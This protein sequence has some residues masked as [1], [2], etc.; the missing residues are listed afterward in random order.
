[1]QQNNHLNLLGQCVMNSHWLINSRNFVLNGENIFGDIKA[2][3]CRVFSFDLKK[4]TFKVFD[5]EKMLFA[6]Q[7]L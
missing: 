3:I 2:N 7:I 6:Q 5:I 1:M 4:I